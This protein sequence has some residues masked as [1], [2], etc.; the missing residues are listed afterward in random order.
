[1]Q[2]RGALDFNRYFEEKYN[3][4]YIN[5]AWQEIKKCINYLGDIENKDRYTFN[6]DAKEI[7]F[8]TLSYCLDHKKSICFDVKIKRLKYRIFKKIYDYT[9]KRL[10]RKKYI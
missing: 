5:K 6:E 2:A 8:Q 10:I 3:D 4:F 1:M 9:R 7:F